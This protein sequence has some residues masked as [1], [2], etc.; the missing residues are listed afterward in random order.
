MKLLTIQPF[1]KQDT[2][3]KAKGSEEEAAQSIHTY[4]FFVMIQFIHLA[5][6]VILFLEAVFKLFYVKVSPQPLLQKPNHFFLVTQC[7]LKLNFHAG[8]VVFWEVFENFLREKQVL[9]SLTTRKV[10][11]SVPIETHSTLHIT[12]RQIPTGLSFFRMI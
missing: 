3:A 5:N 4:M 7:L 12:E 6:A 9:K 8:E 1:Y 11:I 2:K 10:R